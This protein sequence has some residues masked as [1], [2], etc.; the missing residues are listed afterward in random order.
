MTAPSE[1][2]AFVFQVPNEP[3]LIVKRSAFQYQTCGTGS[4]LLKQGYQIDL[5]RPWTEIQRIG[6][7]TFAK[8]DDTLY[9]ITDVAHLKIS[10][11]M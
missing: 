10:N 8:R 2:V 5:S 4:L 7:R 9:D 1:P 6:H 11:L 3:Y